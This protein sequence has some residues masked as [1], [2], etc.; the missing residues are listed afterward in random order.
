MPARFLHSLPK[1]CVTR[2]DPAATGLSLSAIIP[3]QALHEA[4]MH[5]DGLGFFLEDITGLHVA[6]GYELDYYFAH[7]KRPGRVCLRLIA[8]AGQPEAPTISDVFPGADWHE[9]ETADFI[10]VTFVGHPNPQPLLMPEDS[11]LHPLLREPAALRSMRD[12]LPA[13]C[14]VNA[15][16]ESLD[17]R[18]HGGPSGEDRP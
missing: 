15:R 3:V 1:A 16:P 5:M 11:A 13:R 12:T 9:R 4:A 6:E 14:F 18:S 10:G 17:S 2:M 8:P 7:W